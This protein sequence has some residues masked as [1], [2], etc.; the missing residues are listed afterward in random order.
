M[1]Q[2]T[3]TSLHLASEDITGRFDHESWIQ[4][5]HWEREFIFLVAEGFRIH[6]QRFRFILSIY[7]I[8][9]FLL[10]LLGEVS[11]LALDYVILI[12]FGHRNNLSFNLSLLYSLSLLY[13]FGHVYSNL[14][15]KTAL[16]HLH[17]SGSWKGIVGNDWKSSA[18]LGK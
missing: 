1:R 7:F 4:I 6:R 3:T 16:L 9:Y 2:G 13:H 10:S 15:S 5:C 8:P 12:D 18:S 11:A 17:L 14:E